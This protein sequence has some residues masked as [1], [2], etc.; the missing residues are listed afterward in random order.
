MNGGRLQ[1]LDS[2]HFI[3]AQASMT[4]V[5]IQ[6]Y[7]FAPL[8]C[9]TYFQGGGWMLVRRVKQE[10]ASWHPTT[11]SLAGTQQ[12]YGVYSTSTSNDTFG[13]PYTSWLSSSTEIMFATGM[14]CCVVFL[15][16]H[17]F[18]PRHGGIAGDKSKWLITTWGDI[19]N[20]GVS[21]NDT[22]RNVIRSSYSSSPCKAM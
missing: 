18:S 17:L 12:A 1:L 19:H 7:Q 5:G 4:G 11:D 9:D 22:L 6:K 20:D 2:N 16:R 13:I 14:L 15:T 8:E 10:D 21:Y 3:L